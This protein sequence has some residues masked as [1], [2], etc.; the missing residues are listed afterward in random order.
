MFQFRP[1][2]NILAAIPLFIAVNICALLVWWLD[3]S[4]QTMPLMLGAIGGGLVDL[5]NRL[6]GRLKSIFYT[7]LAFS[8]SSFGIQF[9]V[10]QPL[11]FLLIITFMTFGFTMLGAVGMRYNTIA[12]GGLVVAVY[13]L[14]VYS[15]QT[16]SYLNPILI[17]SG[18]LLYSIVTVLVHLVFPNRPVQE[19]VAKSFNA[20]ADYLEVKADFFDPDSTDEL[21]K[22][23]V[24]L[25]MKNSLLVNAFNTARNALFSRISGQHRQNRTNKLLRYYFIAQ[26]IHERANSSHFNYQLLAD[27]L[28]N[29]DL[30][31]RIQRLLELQ[32]T[33]CR[34]I[35]QC[36]HQNK[37]YR[38]D[39]RLTRAIQGIQ[40]SFELYSQQ[41]TQNTAE[42]FHIKTLLDNLTGVDWQLRHLE[43]VQHQT[44]QEQTKIYRD[45]IRGLGAIFRTIYAHLT[46]QSPL[47]R[48]AVRLSI[49]MFIGALIVQLGELERGYWILLT[50]IFVCQPNYSA[51]KLR[52]KQRII[53][54][55][56]G[57]VVGSLL[58]YFTST[59]EAK[60]G[61]VVVTST[62]FY[63]FRISRHGLSTFFITIQVLA[64]FDIM[65][66]D[67]YAAM[68][69][70]ILY[71]LIGV[72]IS[73]LAVSYLWPDWKYLQLN[74]V[75]KQA[76]KHNAAYLLWIVAE[77]QFG[78]GN[79][80]KY[81]TTRRYANESATALSNTLSNMNNEPNKYA[82]YLAQGFELLKI[83]ASLL[84]YI[85]ALGAYREQM[86]QQ[87]QSA[88][89]CAAF[90][91]TAKKLIGLLD[92]MENIEA[93]EWTSQQYKINLRLQEYIAQQPFN[94]AIQQ[95][96]MI[97][98][99]LPALF[100][101]FSKV[102]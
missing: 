97:N 2:A 85:S 72:A 53:G 35:A 32:A 59:L 20:L 48:H 23:Q 8:V 92:N 36:L 19:N 47:F 71:T 51:T 25:A 40:H 10:E 101:A 65:G 66:L 76:M 14:L 13:T 33:A 54:T 16:H 43:Q 74:K 95:L 6:S 58:P 15:P 63:F 31:F 77:L 5:D 17:L 75:T 88:E 46:L 44:A 57:V 79:D 62:L 61:I 37:D 21:E 60:L 7:L 49:V 28:K 29:T 3:I 26:D 80:A 81:R 91:P 69:P 24:Q 22:K 1:S 52:L 27:S 50:I 45:N 42:H 34:H 12:F 83:N 87:P 90:Y 39:P 41:H 99:M 68:P 67:L 100:D 4:Q 55:L 73:W 86:T 38:Y 94:A 96:N 64:G 82:Q 78:R 89:F 70:R 56:A 11:F 102:K 93:K 84:S 98:Q 30:I 18:T 9:F